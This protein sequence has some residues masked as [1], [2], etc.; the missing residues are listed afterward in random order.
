M[1][2]ADYL[3]KN[4]LSAD[5]PKKSKKRKRKDASTAGLVIADD[6]VT[7]WD[8]SKTK[9]DDRRRPPVLT[10]GQTA[11]FRK[12]KNSAWATISAP[13]DAEQADADAIIR[14]A[15]ADNEAMG[16]AEDDAPAVVDEEEE[17]EKVGGLQLAHEVQAAAE[18][19]RRSEK[20]RIERELAEGGTAAQETIYRDA[21]GRVINVA[22]KRAEARRKAEEE[23]RKKKEEADQAKGDVQLAMREARKQELDEAKYLTVARTADDE[24][25]NEELKEVQRWNDPAA[26]FLTKAP[27]KPT[28][29]A[30]TR[31]GPSKPTYQGAF[32][33]NR[34]GI[35]PGS[36]WDGV[37]R[38][39][40]FEKK[41]FAA[42]NK[43]KDRKQLEYQWEMDA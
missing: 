24:Q 12:K 3:A 40:G 11:D 19:K 31:R 41:W 18:K 7:G 21:S 4:Y 39:N 23:E 30:S 33:P 34:Y 25:M 43:V 36:R 35:R 20:R 32:D 27:P 13:T 15:A 6:N 22:M 14:Q 42:R 28:S 26:G 37:D 8:N 9:D 2:L 5:T 29:G 16:N 17:P 1:S 10:S 38:G